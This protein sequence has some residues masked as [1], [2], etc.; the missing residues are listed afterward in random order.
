MDQQQL[1]SLTIQ[2][3]KEKAEFICEWTDPIGIPINGYYNREEDMYYITYDPEVT[4][5]KK[6]HVIYEKGENIMDNLLFDPFSELKMI[7]RKV[8]GQKF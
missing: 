4:Q 5:E 8:Y 7:N 2:D 3:V 1:L 6:E